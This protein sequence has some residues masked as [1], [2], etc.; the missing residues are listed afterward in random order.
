MKA[1]TKPT[2]GARTAKAT[3]VS[4][5]RAIDRRDG[6]ASPVVK[7]L[8]APRG[9]LYPPGDMLVASPLAI[10]AIV[11]RIPRGRV[12]TLV[13]LREALAAAHG[14][15]YTCPMTTGI[16]LR[17]A[18]EAAEEERAMGARDVTPWWRVVRETGALLEKVPGGAV[19]QRV[20]LEGEGVAMRSGRGAVVADVAWVA[21]TPA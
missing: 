13:A 14:A 3:R 8:D 11:R 16:F 10:D 19:R 4:P 20:L 1:P 12:C 5:T 6:H 18:A 17:I 2:T 21:W 15:D 7:R 9:R